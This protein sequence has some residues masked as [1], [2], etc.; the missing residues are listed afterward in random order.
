VNFT[1]LD[2]ECPDDECSIQPSEY[3]WIK[4]DHPTAI[5][6]SR[7]RIWDSKK[8]VDCLARGILKKPSSGDVPK[9]T[10]NKVLKIALKSVEL[11]SDFK[12]LL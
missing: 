2:D 10:V 6:F 7:A 5:A 12:K 1:T 8:I 11:N 9:A 3:K 4:D